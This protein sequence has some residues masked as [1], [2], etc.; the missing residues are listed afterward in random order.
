[1]SRLACV[2]VDFHYLMEI[3]MMQMNLI[4]ILAD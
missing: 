3:E 4:T 2:L 1:M